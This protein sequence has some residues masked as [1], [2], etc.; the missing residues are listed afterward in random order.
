M[1]NIPGR[2]RETKCRR[3]AGYKSLNKKTYKILIFKIIG[4]TDSK[5]HKLKGIWDP[6]GKLKAMGPMKHRIWF[7]MCVLALL[8]DVI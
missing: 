5:L 7:T 4:T 1:P 3:N 8:T 2:L 6:I